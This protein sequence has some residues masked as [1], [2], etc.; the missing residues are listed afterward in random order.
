M[1]KLSI[2]T[3]KDLCKPI[4]RPGYAYDF[5]VETGK[6]NPDDLKPLVG[7]KVYVQTN[8]GKFDFCAKE[9]DGQVTV[10]D[11]STTTLYVKA[12]HRPTYRQEL[13]EVPL[14]QLS[15]IEWSEKITK[16]VRY[17]KGAMER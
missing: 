7:Q 14:D 4:G 2:T 6:I 16:R 12:Q 15:L 8:G 17:T 11:I 3:T 13:V 5:D 10:T 9:Y 1:T